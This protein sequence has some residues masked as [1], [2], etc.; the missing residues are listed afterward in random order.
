MSGHSHWSTIKHD[1]SVEDARRGKTF[2]KVSRLIT[3]AVKKGGGDPGANPT[4][5]KAIEKAREVKM[6]NDLIERAVRRALG[7][8]KGGEQLAEAVLEG[9]GPGGVGF[10]VEVLTDNKNRTVAEIRNIFSRHGGN[11][12]EAGSTAYIF[13]ADPRQPQFR[14]PL[15]DKEAEVR[16]LNLTREL[17]DHD[18]VQEVYSNYQLSG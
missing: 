17:Q 10:L 16:I 18:D 11:L 2:T 13:A 15:P 4:L 1:K 3:V 14:V 5:R 7:D 6:G 8:G 9:Y 12:G